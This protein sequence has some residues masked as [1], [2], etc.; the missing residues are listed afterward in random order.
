MD[1]IKALIMRPEYSWSAQGVSE[2]IIALMHD[3]WKILR[4]DATDQDIV[5]FMIR[6]NKI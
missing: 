1:E 5:Y 2:E 6:Y 4:A 3:G